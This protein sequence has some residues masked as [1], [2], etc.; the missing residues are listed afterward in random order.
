MNIHCKK[1]TWNDIKSL[2]DKSKKIIPSDF[3]H[4]PRNIIKHRDGY[5]SKYVQAVKLY[6]K[7]VISN[8]DKIEIHKL[9]LEFY[10]HYEREEARLPTMK[11]CFHYLLHVANRIQT[12]GPCWATWQFPIDVAVIA[13]KFSTSSL[14]YAQLRTK[15]GILIG[16]RSKK[17]K[18]I[19]KT[20][21]SVAAQMAIDI[22]SAYPNQPSIFR[23]QEFY[24]YIEY[25][26]VHEF[27]RKQYMLAGLEKYLKII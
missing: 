1:K 13:E 15:D 26:F 8:I 10:K 2:M 3:G 20:N 12:T 27:E 23:I 21:Y 22:Y 19:A 16:L 25:Y 24:E 14:R 17:R 4:P 6:Q 5:K 9:F 7:C 18:N 11:I